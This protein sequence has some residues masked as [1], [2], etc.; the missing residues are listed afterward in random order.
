MEL[1][2]IGISVNVSTLDHVHH[3]NQDFL[4]ACLRVRAQGM[5]LSVAPKNKMPV[6]GMI[7]H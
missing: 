4:R 1:F 7:E 5:S 3:A 2:D 6:Y